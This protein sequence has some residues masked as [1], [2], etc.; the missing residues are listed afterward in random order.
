MDCLRLQVEPA[1]LGSIN[2][3]IPD[4]RASSIDC[5]QLSRFDLKNEAESL[6]NVFN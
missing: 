1:K 2:T 6:C 4:I 5:D 3:A